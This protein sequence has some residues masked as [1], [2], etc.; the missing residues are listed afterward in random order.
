[1]DMTISGEAVCTVSED[2]VARNTRTTKSVSNESPHTRGNPTTC[3]TLSLRVSHE[4]PPETLKSQY[5]SSA[6]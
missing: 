3:V 6:I 4:G 5:V 2:V 1:M